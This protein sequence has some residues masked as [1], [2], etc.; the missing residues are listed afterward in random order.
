MWTVR[1]TRKIVE[2]ATP[3]SRSLLLQDFNPR[4]SFAQ[5]ESH[6]E[7][8][9]RTVIE[10]CCPEIE[11]E[12]VRLVARCHIHPKIL[13]CILFRHKPSAITYVGLRLCGVSIMM[14]F[15]EN[16]DMFLSIVLRGS[17]LRTPVQFIVHCTSDKRIMQRTE[18]R[19]Q[20]MCRLLTT[21][22]LSVCV[23]CFS[24]AFVT[25]GLTFYWKRS[26]Q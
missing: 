8:E 18:L 20:V 1:Y 22:V 25:V 23:S 6:V 4:Y 5:V 19:L 2:P 13:A 26:I 3:L 16:I 10:W 9:K 15:T 11:P 21:S 14:N 24:F 17:S 12:T 7:T